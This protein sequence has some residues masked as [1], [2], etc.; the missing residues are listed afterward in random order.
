MVVF[1]RQRVS[2]ELRSLILKGYTSPPLISFGDRCNQ[3]YGAYGK[4]NID[5]NP[6]SPTYGQVTSV[7]NDKYW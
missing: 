5:T 4:A 2:L 3:G 1:K 6:A 7:T